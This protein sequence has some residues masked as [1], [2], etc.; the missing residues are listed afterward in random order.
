MSSTLTDAAI[1]TLGELARCIDCKTTLQGCACCPNC[2]RSYP[3]PDG[4]LEAIGPARRPQPDRGRL[5]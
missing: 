3:I 4:I 5:L 2:D 1:P